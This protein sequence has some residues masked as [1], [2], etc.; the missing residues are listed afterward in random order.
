[1]SLSPD[2]RFTQ[3]SL[4]DYL[5]CPRRFEL[6]YVMQQKWPAIQSEPVLEQEFLMEEG[7]LFHQMAQRFVAGLAPD[8]ILDDASTP[9]LNRWWQNLIQ[10]DPLKDLPSQRYAELS[11]S[12]PLAGFRLS[13]QYDLIA[14]APGQR[15]VIVDWKTSARKPSPNQLKNRI[16]TRVYRYLL[17][18]SGSFLN[19]NLPIDPNQV[20]MIYWFTEFPAQP[21]RFAYDKEQYKA[22][23]D[24]LSD[25]ITEITKLQPG[26][27]YLTPDEKKCQLCNYRSMC[28]RGQKAG[29]WQDQEEEEPKAAGDDTD[30]AFEQIGEIEF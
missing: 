8:L 28:N 1:M 18:A 29:D 7:Q 27:F 3:R 10:Y 9:D 5:D 24:Y 22:D 30:L 6:R 2:F 23:H 19:D 21:V 11:L 17:A 25:L 12:A 16:Q 4:G 26:Q 15:A 13:A 20:E 14:I